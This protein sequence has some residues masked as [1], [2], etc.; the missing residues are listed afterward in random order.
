MKKET[1]NNQSELRTDKNHGM[2]RRDFFKILGGGIFIFFRPW[3]VLDLTGQQAGQS[4][5]LPKDYNAFLRIAEDGTVTCFT[6]KIEM[7]Q[8]IITSLPQM[9]ADELNVP[10]EKVKMVMGDTDLCPY[11]QGTWGSLS[12]R[13]FGPYMRAAAAEARGVLLGIAS[14][15]LGVPVSQ[16]DVKD[17]MITDTKNP[18]NSVS[19][20]QLTK[21]KKIE[22]FL[23]V[24][25]PV[26][27]YTKFNYIGK[28]YN[29]SDA[30]P[31]V[32]GEAKYTGD[33]KLPGM[34]FAR[35]LRPPSHGAKLKSVDYSAA[36]KIAGTKV[37]RD[38]DLIAVINENHDRA[39]EAIVKIK[40]EYS[41]DEMPVNDKTIFEWMLKADSSVDVVRSNGDMETG[42]QLSEKTFESEF[43]DP[44]LA[45]AAIETHTALAQLEGDKIT[46]WASTQ[47][48]F[49]LQN[50]ISRELNFPIE[51]V[52]VISP[53]VG[54]GFGGK[55]EYQQ[56]IEAAKLAKLTG[57]PIMLV[58]TRE[59]EFF[60][61]TFHPAGVVKIK[62][63]IDKSGLIKLWDY[64][65]Y[66]AGS[67][68]SDTIYDVPNNK[69][70]S[71]S[72]KKDA[73][74]VHPLATG[75]W[76]APSNNTNTFAREIQIDI[77]AAAAGIDPLEFRLKNLKDE[78]MIACLKAVADKFG[79]VAGKTPSGRGIG[80][81]V[82]IDAG[83][84]VAHM[85]EVKVDKNTGKV[86]VVR[87][88]CAQDMGLCVNPEGATIQM[89]G[90]ITMG[91]GYALAEEVLFEGGNIQNRG[92]DS[93]DIP[94]FSWLP[95]ID[96]VIL[97]R[98][99]KPPQGGGEPAIIA[100]GAVV[101]NAIFDATGARLYRVPMTPARVLE[102]LKKV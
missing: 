21:G 17:G 11:D 5:S 82:G 64:N 84:W 26:E 71:Y 14:A 93:Y 13:V 66:G 8:G 65:L 56:G 90:C 102:A 101:A 35:I 15:Q 97:D 49:G 87:I 12:T 60:Y 33:M 77:M 83:S 47:S 86:R 41:F 36:E 10:L 99:D 76:R 74:P 9:M 44:Y 7:G 4:K 25:P 16:L 58:W 54:G 95:K 100:I 52:R 96:T 72:Q 43:H 38:G 73:P 40:A 80:V 88:A 27:D 68:G 19:Y 37:V 67:R 32:T 85:A 46:V 31:K 39:D 30:I 63:G 34:V 42:R 45:H 1:T 94:R 70:T 18:K 28:S 59:E 78:K 48:P 3:N 51:K 91:L 23:D 98:K 24:K 75:A 55:G 29:H 61:D 6:G 92:F 20:A 62:S 22:K 69:T 2:E 89:E 53:F 50:G 57:K 81:A 79:Y